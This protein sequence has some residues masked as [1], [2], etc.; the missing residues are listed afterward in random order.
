MCDN[1]DNNND[2]QYDQDQDMAFEIWSCTKC[3]SQIDVSQ[4]WKYQWY[5][6]MCFKEAHRDAKKELSCITEHQYAGPEVYR[7]ARQQYWKEFNAV[8]TSTVRNREELLEEA[9][10]IVGSRIARGQVYCD[11]ATAASARSL[12][13]QRMKR[14]IK[15]CL[16]NL[17]E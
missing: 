16:E 2:G 6:T 4:V 11:E 8:L 5:C 14:A 10:H 3:G 1:C 13:R 9:C 12:F 15:E 17:R 7:F